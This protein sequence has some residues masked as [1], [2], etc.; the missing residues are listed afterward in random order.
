MLVGAFSVIVKLS[1]IFG[2]LRLKLY[3][4]GGE[5]D[6]ELEVGDGDGAAHQRRAQHPHP[7]RRE[8]EAAQRGEEGH[9]AGQVHVALEHRR[10]EH[11]W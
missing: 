10:L 11:G 7:Q 8:G 6:G 3:R 2:N 4:E 9:R 5:G 1:V